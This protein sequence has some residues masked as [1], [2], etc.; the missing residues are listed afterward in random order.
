MFEQILTTTLL[1]I[2]TTAGAYLVH[3]VA[4]FFKAK[5]DNDKQK[6]AVEIVDKIILEAVKATEHTVK[7][8]IMESAIGDKLSKRDSADIMKSA[9]SNIVCQ[10]P[11]SI[12]KDINLSIG[13]MSKY[14]E[15]KIEATLHDL[16]SK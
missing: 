15:N 11:H 4:T 5:T 6:K 10:I 1:S 8:D 3:S 2:A 9:Y 7:K 13:N 12:E 16:K 14:I